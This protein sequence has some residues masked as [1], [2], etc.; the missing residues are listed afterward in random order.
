[1]ANFD[2]PRIKDAIMNAKID[3]KYREMILM[4]YGIGYE[5]P[6]SI[7]EIGKKFK[8]RGLKLREEMEKAEALAFNILKTKDLYDIMIKN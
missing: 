5:K 2:D 1:M 8:L 6:F 4:R 7:K 3:Q